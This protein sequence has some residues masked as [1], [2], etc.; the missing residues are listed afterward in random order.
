[1]SVEI[2]LLFVAH[3]EKAP[4]DPDRRYARPD[5]TSDDGRT[6]RARLLDYNETSRSNALNL[7]P[8]YQLYAHDVYRALVDKFGA[9][10]VFILSAGWGLI[11]ATFLTPLYDITFSAQAE[12]WKRRRKADRYLDF[13]MMPDD[14]ADVAFL[15]GKDYLPLF[16]ALT[17]GFSG[18]KIVFFNA[19]HQPELPAGFVPLRYRISTRTNWHY[20][21]ARDLI[22][23]TVGSLWA[24]LPAGR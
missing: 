22:A 21:C 11:P 6:W 17:A 4:A 12:S 7:L 19:A 5:D 2:A 1:M 14:G 24:E 10:E 20:A 3:P 23:G 16:C 9:T 18:R 15:G 13:C 8:A